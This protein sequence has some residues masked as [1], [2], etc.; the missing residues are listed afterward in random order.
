MIT[1]LDFSLA[2]EVLPSTVLIQ[3]SVRAETYSCCVQVAKCFSELAAATVQEIAKLRAQ[4]KN[5]VR[6]DREL[7]AFVV[8]LPS[9]ATSVNGAALANDEVEEFLL[10]PAEVRRNDTSARSVNE[11]TGERMLQDD[12]ISD[13]VRPQEV[14]PLGNYAVQITWEDGFNQ[15]A[16]FELLQRLERMGAEAAR[17]A[18]LERQVRSV[19]AP[20]PEFA[21]V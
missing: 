7:G 11:W 10:H 9:V 1:L 17:A 19:D 14:A 8:R 13:D 2:G 16:P 15:V 20:E 5:S 6:F 21:D 18:A 4:R 12:D 3:S